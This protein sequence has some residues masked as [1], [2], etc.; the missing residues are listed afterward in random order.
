QRG[1]KPSF[2]TAASAVAGGV[3]GAALGGW[4]ARKGYDPR[5][6]GAALAGA[7]GLGAWKLD[8]NLRLASYGLA[9]SGAGASVL[10]WLDNDE[11]RATSAPAKSEPKAAPEKEHGR[12]VAHAGASNGLRQARAGG[13]G[14]DRAFNKV[15]ERLHRIYEDDD[16]DAR[17]DDDAA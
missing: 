11:D 13:G 6:V 15:R 10:E 14:L 8:G 17:F 12:E 16:D 5:W 4:A 3:G 2:W 9:A 1:D 7:G